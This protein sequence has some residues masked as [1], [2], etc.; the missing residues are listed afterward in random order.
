[1]MT[2]LTQRVHTDLWKGRLYFQKYQLFDHLLNIQ[3]SLNSASERYVKY[4]GMLDRLVNSFA[5]R[6][7]R[8]PI[9]LYSSLKPS[10]SIEEAIEEG[11]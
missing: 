1:M 5:N 2:L 10:R 11:K 8:I 7:Q 4:K 3:P 6:I 9:N